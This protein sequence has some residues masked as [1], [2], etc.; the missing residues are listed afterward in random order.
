MKI[1][2]HQFCK[3]S[4]HKAGKGERFHWKP[5][6]ITIMKPLYIKAVYANKKTIEINAGSGTGIFRNTPGL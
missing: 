5:V 1:I 2:N 3:I 6:P 4:I